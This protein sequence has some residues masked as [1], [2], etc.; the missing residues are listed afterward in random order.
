MPETR[1]AYAERVSQ[2]FYLNVDVNRPAAARYGLTVSDVQRVVSSEIGGMNIAEN[3][4]GRK[5]FPIAV[6][7]LH[8]FSDTSGSLSQA[9]IPTPSGQQIPVSQVARVYYSRGPAMI[10]DEDG[11]L[12]GY[13]YLNVKTSDFGGFVNRA[14]SLLN[15]KL[16]LPTGYT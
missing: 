8:D 5:R 16:T 9:L 12:T 13:V 3:I 6:R 14:N 1:S 7:Y 2:G 4:E 10:R 15:Q 11:S